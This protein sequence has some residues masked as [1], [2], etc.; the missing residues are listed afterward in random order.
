[1]VIAVPTGIFCSQSSVFMCI[2]KGVFIG[3]D[4]GWYANIWGPLSL[5]CALQSQWNHR[6]KTFSKVTQTNIQLA[7][8]KTNSLSW[9][10]NDIK[11]SVT[12]LIYLW[13]KH[14]KTK[15]QALSD[16]KCSIK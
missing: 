2:F 6:I 14:G 16:E 1:M 10:F 13:A 5:R 15:L 3:S 4:M 8:L 7:A 9:K 11:F 12:Y